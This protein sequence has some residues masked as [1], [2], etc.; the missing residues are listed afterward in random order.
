MEWFQTIIK[1]YLPIVSEYKLLQ[2]GVILVGSFIVAWIIQLVVYR[3]Q[4]HGT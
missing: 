3:L 4:F 2:A 1:D